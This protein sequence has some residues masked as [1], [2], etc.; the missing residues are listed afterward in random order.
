MI[1]SKNLVFFS[2]LSFL[3][4]LVPC[5]YW[6][7][8]SKSEFKKK[9][10]KQVIVMV[11]LSILLEMLFFEIRYV[12]LLVI[13]SLVIARIQLI[14]VVF[15]TEDFFESLSESDKDPHELAVA[16]T[17]YKFVK[18]RRAANNETSN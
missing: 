2:Q 7:L 11:G 18:K 1:F 5:F 13:L 14:W 16:Y 4:M 3:L 9:V 6:Y 8:Y 12:W 15:Q 10:T 17:F